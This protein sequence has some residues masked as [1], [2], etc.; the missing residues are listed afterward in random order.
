MGVPGRGAM[1]PGILDLG[2]VPKEE[3]GLSR[4]RIG[5]GTADGR[6]EFTEGLIALPGGRGPKLEPWF[7]P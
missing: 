3:I 6:G 7:G 5:L 4:G 2:G 1:G